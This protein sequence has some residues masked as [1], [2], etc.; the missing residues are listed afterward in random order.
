MNEDIKALN[1]FTLFGILRPANTVVSVIT[2]TYQEC[3]EAAENADSNL[4]GLRL[5]LPGEKYG[6]E[7]ESEILKENQRLESETRENARLEAV[8]CLQRAFQGKY[9]PNQSPLREDAV[10]LVCLSQHG[11]IERG[12]MDCEGILVVI[13]PEQA[14]ALARLLI[15]NSH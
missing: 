4:Y 12:L 10:P 1:R 5:G 8:G 6:E 11:M 9:N 14:Y 2:G 13:S 15:Q 7:L 3:E